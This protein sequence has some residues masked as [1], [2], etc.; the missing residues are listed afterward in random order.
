MRTLFKESGLESRSLGDTCLG[1][2]VV[3]IAVPPRSPEFLPQS[4]VEMAVSL[5]RC[6]A[7]LSA[8]AGFNKGL[9]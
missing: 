6:P 7:C 5:K 1:L 2:V 4:V 9:A 3:A 8:A